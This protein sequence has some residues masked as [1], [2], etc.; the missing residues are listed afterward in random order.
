MRGGSKQPDGPCPRHV[1]GDPADQE[2]PHG[3]GGLLGTSCINRGHNPPLAS[4][5][6]CTSVVAGYTRHHPRTLQRRMR[7]IFT[8]NFRHLVP[9]RPFC[10]LTACPCC[11]G[12]KS[13]IP[14][15]PPSRL[16]VFSAATPSHSPPHLSHTPSSLWAP[17]STPQTSGT[18]HRR[19]HHLYVGCMEHSSECWV[20]T[21]CT[22]YCTLG[23]QQVA[24]VSALL[25]ELA[26]PGP[27][28]ELVSH[29][30][31]SMPC[32]KARS[33]AGHSGTSAH[34]LC[35]QAWQVGCG[36]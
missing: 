32:G 24:G 22:G 12:T 31:G 30:S 20:H 18:V 16:G 10:P 5:W 9:D 1:P 4:L 33:A 36:A 27:T 6:W 19:Q 13:T 17:P 11:D 8:G 35:T 29:C 23:G 21:G 34:V 2:L 7:T 25:S 26:T 28:A 3:C 15:G 14:S